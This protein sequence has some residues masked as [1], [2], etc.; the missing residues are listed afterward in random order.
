MRQAASI[1][2]L[3]SAHDQFRAFGEPE[4]SSHLQKVD[5]LHIELVMFYEIPDPLGKLGIGQEASA[6]NAG[7]VVYTKVLGMRDLRLAGA[8]CDVQHSLPADPSVLFWDRWRQQLC[9]ERTHNQTHQACLLLY[10]I[11][12]PSELA[13]RALAQDLAG[14]DE[15]CPDLFHELLALAKEQDSA[16]DA[17]IHVGSVA[18]GRSFQD[19]QEI[20]GCVDDLK[21]DSQGIGDSLGVAPA[22][23]IRRMAIAQAK[24][25]LEVHGNEFQILAAHQFSRKGAV[26]SSGKKYYRFHC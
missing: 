12:L 13:H 26:Q 7:V 14:D 10:D 25:R 9:R 24:R 17:G 5:I 18:V 2:G 1:L 11:H 22:S 23:Q 20:A 3:I 21:A 6:C 19:I 4:I 15:G 16:I 8:A